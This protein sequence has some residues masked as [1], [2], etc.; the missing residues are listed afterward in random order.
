MDRPICNAC[1]RRFVAI[2]YISE[3]KKHY[4]TRCDSCTRKNRKAKPPVPR[5]QLDGYKKK[6]TCDRCR[7]IAKSG[8]QILVYHIVILKIVILQTLEVFV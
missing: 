1:N 6:K 4:R 5:W 2:N 8:A 7:F 3:G